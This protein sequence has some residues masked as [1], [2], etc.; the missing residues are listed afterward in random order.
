MAGASGAF[1][2][3][4][5]GRRVA[6]LP[7]ANPI[8]TGSFPFASP[9]TTIDVRDACA[10][11]LTAQFT[12]PGTVRALALPGTVAAVVDEAQ[13]G[14]RTIERYDANSGALLG[15]TE[16]AAGDSLA[17]KGNTVIFA[18]GRKIEAMDAMTGDVRL[19]ATSPGAP[20]GLSVSGKRLA[21]A[22]NARGRGRVLALT[23]P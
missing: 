2:L 15:T 9:D 4:V 19:L 5:A 17:L 6:I 7:A 20:I 18:V 22:V 23:L 13:G 16:I 14:A 8:P 1:E 11:T 21:W 3:A 12:P 10:G